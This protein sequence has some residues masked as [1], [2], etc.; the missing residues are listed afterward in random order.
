MSK[1]N[2]VKSIAELFGEDLKTIQAEIL[3]GNYIASYCLF[4]ELKDRRGGITNITAYNTAQ[5][6]SLIGRLEIVKAAMLNKQVELVR[7]DE[8]P[9]EDSLRGQVDDILK[10]F[11]IQKNEKPN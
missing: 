10:Q 7:D 11:K 5:I 1:S 8:I 6:E 4:V 9:V 2:D 3:E